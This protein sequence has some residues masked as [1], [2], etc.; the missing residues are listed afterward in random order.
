MSLNAET[1]T[2]TGTVRLMTDLTE[3]SFKAS[4]KPGQVHREI[5]D[6]ANN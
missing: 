1:N 3:N 2:E 5:H 4:L 6:L